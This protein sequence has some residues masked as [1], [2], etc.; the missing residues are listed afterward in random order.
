ME[1]GLPGHGDM[2]TFH[3]QL[4]Q[5]PSQHAKRTKQIDK[6]K[7]ILALYMNATL[8]LDCFLKNL[9]DYVM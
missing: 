2:C 1:L 5:K 9:L 4:G 6:S 3:C 7:Y 8:P